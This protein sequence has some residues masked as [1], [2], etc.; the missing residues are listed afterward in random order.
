MVTVGLEIGDVLA[1]YQTGETVRDPVNGEMVKLPD[2]RRCL[3]VVF[4][5]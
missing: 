4:D 2:V 3:D 5:L 1:I